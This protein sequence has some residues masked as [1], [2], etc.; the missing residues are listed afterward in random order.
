MTTLTDTFTL[1]AGDL[2][3][4][5]V[6]ELGM[7][8]I[9]LRH[10]EEELLG[11]GGIPFLHPWANRLAAHDYTVDGRTV[12]LPESGAAGVPVAFG[13]HPYLLLPGKWH[14]PDRA[15]VCVLDDDAI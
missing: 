3:A 10:A 13:F 15:W 5:F 8:G 11:D 12:A 7:I 6:P 14:S 4:D 9:S 1:A 2:E